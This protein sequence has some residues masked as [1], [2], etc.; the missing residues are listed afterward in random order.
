MA[1]LVE[2]RSIDRIPD[3]ERTTGFWPLFLLWSGFTIAIGRLWQGGVITGSGFWNAVAAY[4]IAQM[5]MVYIGIGA[6]MGASEGLPGTMIMRSAFGVRGRI[7]PSVPIVIATIGWFGLQLGMTASALD[8]IIKTLYGGWGMPM[9]V[10]YVLW[11]FLMGIVSIYGY[12][13]VM[14]FQKFVSPLLIFLIPWMLYKMFVRYDLLAEF[15]RPRETTMSIYEA[16][17]II[18]GGGLAML[19][20]AAD[21]SRYAKSRAIAFTG[22]MTA[23]WSVGIIMAIVGMMGAVLVG[24]WDPAGIVDRLGLGLIGLLIVVL[25]AWSTNCMNPYWGGIALSTLTTGNK[26][27]PRGIPRATSTAIIVGIGTLTAVFGIY[28]IKGLMTFVSILAGTLGPANGILLADY[29]FLR[30]KG[31]NKLDAPELVKFKGKY[32]YFYGWN[33]VAVTVWIIGVC[34]T[35]AVKSIY[36]LIPP[37]SSFV[38]AGILYYILMKTIGKHYLEISLGEKHD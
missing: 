12:R 7:I 10:Q 38:I 21:S 26:L 8:I 22:Y 15:S 4:V 5:F 33:P 31:T 9:R 2:K 25:A 28:S 19:I 13:V 17:T 34:Y 36:I 6:I 1:E 29:F 24:V 27:F 14:W 16:I 32:W 11:A 23:N 35:M 18:T 20:A 37:I 30:G 3:E